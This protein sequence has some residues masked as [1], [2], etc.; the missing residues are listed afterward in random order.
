MVLGDHS[1]EFIQEVRALALG[2]AIDVLH[3]MPNCEHGFPSCDGVGTNNGVLGGEFIADILWVATL[4]RVEAELV[5]F[6]CLSK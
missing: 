1:Q 2:Q 4:I 6:G 5:V 3:V